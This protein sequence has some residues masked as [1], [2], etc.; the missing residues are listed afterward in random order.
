MS[1]NVQTPPMDAESFD[2]M[3]ADDIE[4]QR[5]ED[6]GRKIAAVMLMLGVTAFHY[7]TDPQLVE[8]HSVY[9]RLY[10]IP[11]VLFAF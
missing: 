5:R 7:T 1:A 6:L 2:R 8:W 10:Y 4:P 11:I 9:R 3:T